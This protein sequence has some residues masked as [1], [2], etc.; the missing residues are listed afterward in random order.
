MKIRIKTTIF[1]ILTNFKFYLNFIW[2][3]LKLLKDFIFLP[4]VKQK[5]LLFNLSLTVDEPIFTPKVFFFL[6]FFKQISHCINYIF[7][8]YVFA[9]Y[10]S[11]YIVWSIGRVNFGNFFVSKEKFIIIIILLFLFLFFFC[12]YEK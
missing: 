2:Q 1:L 12:I 6:R 7:F 3:V 11:S 8:F 10:F 5:E 9:V 4:K